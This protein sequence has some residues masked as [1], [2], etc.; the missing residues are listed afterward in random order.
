MQIVLPGIFGPG[1]LDIRRGLA[2]FGSTVS[3]FFSLPRSA[4]LIE[5]NSRA[6]LAG[7]LS[8]WTVSIRPS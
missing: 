6:A 1:D 2:F 8:R 7:L 5:R 3:R 4:S